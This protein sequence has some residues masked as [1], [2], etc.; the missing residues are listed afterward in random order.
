MTTV[1]GDCGVMF[2]VVVEDGDVDTCETGR[3]DESR[4]KQVGDL[5]WC[6]VEI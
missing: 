6:D 2:F 5:A 1:V 4:T 3:E